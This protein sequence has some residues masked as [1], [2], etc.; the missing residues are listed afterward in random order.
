MQAVRLARAPQRN[1][2]KEGSEELWAMRTSSGLLPRFASLPAD[3]QAR[4]MSAATAEFVEHGFSGASLNRI[5]RK[6]RI[7]KGAMYYYFHDKAHLYVAL[8]ASA[9]EELLR[10]NPPPDLESLDAQGFWP[11][12]EAYAVKLFEAYQANPGLARLLRTAHGVHREKGAPAIE[13]LRDLGKDQLRAIFARGQVLGLI[14]RDMP[15]ELIVTMWSS[16]DS[17]ADVWLLEMWDS[18]DPIQRERHVPM[19][20]DLARRM[21]AP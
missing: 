5:I 19:M 3:K 11:E 12:I 18:L 1:G 9:Y 21:W 13:D 14:R 15:L 6:A 17:V 2:P 4:I 10:D 16:I 8:L 20:V 7:S